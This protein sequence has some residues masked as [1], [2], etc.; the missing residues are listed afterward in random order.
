MS[1]KFAK[2]AVPAEAKAEAPETKAVKEPV[3]GKTTVKVKMPDKPAKPAKAEKADKTDTRKITLTTK[4]NPK[5]EGSKAYETFELY[6]KAKTVQDFLN[7]GG[8]MADIKY[9]EKAGHIKLG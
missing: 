2:K 4:E 5:R 8:K 7:A 1:S 3:K 9:D 6:K